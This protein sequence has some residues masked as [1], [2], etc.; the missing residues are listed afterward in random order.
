MKTK[1]TV[2]VAMVLAMSAATSSAWAGLRTTDQIRAIRFLG[3][4][5]CGFYPESRTVLIDAMQHDPDE[6]ARYEA[7]L[8]IQ[9]QIE[10][11]KGPL[12]PSLGWRQFPD[13]RIVG[14][15]ARMIPGCN[16]ATEAELNETYRQ[17]K[18]SQADQRRKDTQCECDIEQTTRALAECAFATDDDGCFKEP[19]VRVRERAKRVLTLICPPGEQPGTY[20]IPQP[21]PGTPP[22][23][24]ETP[25]PG[26]QAPPIFSMQQGMGES[27]GLPGVGSGAY[28]PFIGGR[29]DM[30]NRMNQFDNMGAAPR[31][32]AFF[33]V[34]WAQSANSG[35]QYTTPTQQLSNLYN[36]GPNGVAAFQNAT[37][38]KSLDQFL[39]ANNNGA[40]QTFNQTPDAMM[41][42]F[43]FEYAVTSDFSVAVQAQYLTPLQDVGQPSE[44]TNPAVYLKHVLYRSE[45]SVLSGMLEVSPEISGPDHG[46]RE[47]TTRVAPAFLYYKELSEDW[48]F[49]GG[50]GMN[51][52]TRG[53]QILTADY[54]L[55]VGFWAYRHE[56]LRRYAQLDAATASMSKPLILGLLPQ[57]EVLGKHVLGNNTNNGLYGLS[58]A[59]PMRAPGT[60]NPDGST[61]VIVPSTGAYN[62]STFNF[63]EP[64]D[65]IDLTFGLTVMLRGNLQWWN[66]YSI[67][68]S[69]H[70]VRS[71]E[72]MS[73]VNLMF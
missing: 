21:M 15:I 40:G 65:V 73:T 12:D 44:F 24:S 38:Y 36:S 53:N 27:G 1:R 19:S 35:T 8:A 22:A 4:V 70:F 14:C 48:F 28:S 23:P 67:P 45:D 5:D 56:S 42:R 49:Q 60:Y 62:T 25:A 43:G 39:K 13:P 7:V 32:R 30:T 66:G 26:T 29:A 16:A 17:R 33:G 57:F 11:S 51:V 72:F 61:N 55:S 6:A 52:P 18:L 31:T 10:R 3:T 69:T 46:I 9:Q 50:A 47:H 2:L 37:G 34:Q 20:N 64:K 59:T 63:V 58:N 41:Y 54:A 68:V 71:Q